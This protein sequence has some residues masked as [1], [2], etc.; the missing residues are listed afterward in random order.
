MIIRDVI[1]YLN[2]WRDDANKPR[3]GKQRG[4]ERA[5][6]ARRAQFRFSSVCSPIAFAFDSRLA[7]WKRSRHDRISRSPGAT[8][9]AFSTPR[10]RSGWP[11]TISKKL[12]HL[13]PTSSTPTS[14]LEMSSKKHES[15]TGKIFNFV[16]NRIFLILLHQFIVLVS[17]IYVFFNWRFRMWLRK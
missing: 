8:S 6:E 3:M 1:L 17:F 2:Q 4:N 10:V 16:Q 14:I 12:S 9:V 5:G 11:S 13:T 7:I 15:S